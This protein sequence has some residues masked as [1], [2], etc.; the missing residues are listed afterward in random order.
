M[1]H[2]IFALSYHPDSVEYEDWDVVSSLEW[3]G[4][5]QKPETEVYSLLGF[6]DK[7]AGVSGDGSSEELEHT[8]FLNA[9]ESATDTTSPEVVSF[10]VDCLK[11]SESKPIWVSFW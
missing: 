8:V 9:I 1:S 7:N 10:L 5:S 3:A 2:K 4:S 11:A 6:D